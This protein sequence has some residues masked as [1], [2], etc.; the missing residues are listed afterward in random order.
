MELLGLL[1][2]SRLLSHGSGV[3]AP[4][5]W[6]AQL[7]LLALDLFLPR[8]QTACPELFRRH[9]KLHVGSDICVVWGSWRGWGLELK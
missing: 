4:F 9:W 5:H 7:W 2:L 1:Q 8:R 6:A 3:Q